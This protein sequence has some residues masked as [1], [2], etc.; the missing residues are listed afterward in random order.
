MNLMVG[1][2]NTNQRLRFANDRD[3]EKEWLLS[4]RYN[5][6][7]HEGLPRLILQLIFQIGIQQVYEY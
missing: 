4:P 2:V 5:Y 6:L 1:L 7:F 3:F